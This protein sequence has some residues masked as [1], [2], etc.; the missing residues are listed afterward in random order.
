MDN[1]S[2]NA[3]GR[4]LDFFRLLIQSARQWCTAFGPVS[5]PVP[6]TRVSVGTVNVTVDATRSCGSLSQMARATINYDEMVEP[7]ARWWKNNPDA[8]RPGF[9]EAKQ[10]ARD[11]IADKDLGEIAPRGKKFGQSWHWIREHFGESRAAEALRNWIPESETNI[12]YWTALHTVASEILRRREV[13]PHMLADWIADT[14]DGTRTKPRQKP[15]PKWYAMLSRDMWI[16]YVVSILWSIG[17]PPTR[18]NASRQESACD[19]VA[20]QINLS[21]EAVASV[22]A[23]A[24]KKSGR[25]PA[26]WECW[27]QDLH[28]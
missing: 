18:N 19:A 13:F 16:C 22:W 7:V 20:Y 2:I 25:M 12:E 17:L 24:K 5:W 15:G 1:D 9:D 11:L 23:R 21:Y 10:I 28:G 6:L 26:P 4:I 27:R 14:L 8:S 3:I